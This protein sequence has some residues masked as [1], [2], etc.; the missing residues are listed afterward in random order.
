MHKLDRRLESKLENKIPPPIVTL[1]FAFFMWA[2]ALLT[3]NEKVATSE[4]TLINIK[5]I[6]ICLF[7]TLGVLSAIAGVISFNR[8]KTTVNPLKP[9]TAS[10]LVT[11]GMFRLSRNPMYLGMAL[12]LCA[13]ACYLESIW[14]LLGIIGYMLYMQRFQIR[15]EEKALEAL[16]GKVFFDYKSR[17]R[18]W[19]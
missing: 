1:I 12:A 18:P 16:F 13:W 11:S 14:S 8:A 9:E 10:A 17:V 19:L 4:H 7:L 15:P 3:S 5:F 2:I 6:A